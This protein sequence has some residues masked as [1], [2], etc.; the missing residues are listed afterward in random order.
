MHEIIRRIHIPERPRTG[1]IEERDHFAQLQVAQR[2]DRRRAR[3]R[4]VLSALGLGRA[5]AGRKRK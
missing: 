5:S 2:V 4:R 3:R 1:I